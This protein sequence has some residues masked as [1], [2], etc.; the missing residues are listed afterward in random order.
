MRDKIIQFDWKVFFSSRRK[1]QEKKKGFLIYIIRQNKNDFFSLWSEN[2][3]REK[4]ANQSRD[5]ADKKSIFSDSVF[6]MKEKLKYI[7]L[8]FNLLGRLISATSK[9]KLMILTASI[10]FLCKLHPKKNFW[11]WLTCFCYWAWGQVLLFY[12]LF[13]LK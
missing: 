2:E 1:F 12:T 10:F 3:R 13:D 11:S 8:R 9:I 4:L 7:I 6:E 5:P